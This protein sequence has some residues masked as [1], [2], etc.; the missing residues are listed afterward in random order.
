MSSYL[1]ATKIRKVV[2]GFTLQITWLLHKALFD[3]Q[4]MTFEC[5]DRPTIDNVFA[6]YYIWFF[7]VSLNTAIERFVT[8]SRR[9]QWPEHSSSCWHKY[10][11]SRSKSLDISWI[12]VSWLNNWCQ[13]GKIMSIQ[14]AM[15]NGPW[16]L[17][18]KDIWP[19]YCASFVTT[20]LLL[21]S[22]IPIESHLSTTEIS[23]VAYWLNTRTSA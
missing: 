15:Y 4:V 13:S 3:F 6:W 8:M 5:K 20:V 19:C 11:P 10:I 22:P 12:L 21:Q 2:Q 9:Q 14:S 1:K 23:D 18:S 17:I 16:V 7:F